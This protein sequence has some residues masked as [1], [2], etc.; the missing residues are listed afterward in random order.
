MAV[1]RGLPAI[2]LAILAC[3]SL[4]LYQE[5]GNKKQLIFSGCLMA[6][7]LDMKFFSMIFIPALLGQ[8][9]IFECA[10][11]NTVRRKITTILSSLS[12]WLGPLFLTFIFISYVLTSIDLFQ[13]YQ[14]Y[15]LIKDPQWLPHQRDLFGWFV[16]KEWF[17]D[18]FDIVLLAL[19]GSIFIMR[20]FILGRKGI[21]FAFVPF[22]LALFSLIL[23]ATHYPVW[24]H[25]RLLVFVPLS[26]LAAYGVKIIFD[27]QRWKALFSPGLMARVRAAI[28]FVT[29]GTV[30]ALAILS[31][32]LKY[33]IF[34]FR[35]S[36]T[37][38]LSKY[39]A[40]I[41]LM[42]KYNS[43]VKRGSAFVV[44]DLPLTPFYAGLLA[45]PYLACAS[46]KRFFAGMFSV[47][48]IQRIIL[49]EK[50]RFIILSRFLIL[51]K[52]ISSLKDYKEIGK[53]CYVLKNTGE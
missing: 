40:T 49:N 23:V 38:Q 48:T 50:P 35:V 9:V 41:D 29:I 18:G 20:R 45:H 12:L 4:F 21:K 34:Q 5:A 7:A 24:Y 10:Q 6:L 15:A 51:P 37:V 47:D 19:A 8:L 44:T 32:P 25:Y 26:W 33:R 1:L 3:Y 52:V 16:L 14:P 31:I 53:N 2:S 13:I 42:K 11:K 28:A 27:W 17:K 39:Q 30:L 36:Q 46:Y 22:A 43:E